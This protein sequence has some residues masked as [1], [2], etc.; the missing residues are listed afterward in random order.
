M[1]KYKWSRCVD[2]FL[3]I[4]TFCRKDLSPGEHFVLAEIIVLWRKFSLI[5]DFC[6]KRFD[7]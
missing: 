1:V 2:K 4:K 3:F 5:K 6:G 7:I